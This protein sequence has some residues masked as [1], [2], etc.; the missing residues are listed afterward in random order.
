MLQ[1]IELIKKQ[2]VGQQFY[3]VFFQGLS[4]F[5]R[6]VKAHGNV[7]DFN[8]LVHTLPQIRYTG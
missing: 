7:I 4:F 1:R 8:N 6:K 3:G 5:L 2:L